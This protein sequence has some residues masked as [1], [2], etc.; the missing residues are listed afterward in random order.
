MYNNLTFNTSGVVLPF[1]AV[2]RHFA[3]GLVSLVYVYVLI[4]DSTCYCIV[5]VSVLMK[6][7]STFQTQCEASCR[8]DFEA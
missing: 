7:I 2:K 8:L 5:M 3:V 1:P 4:M 6:S